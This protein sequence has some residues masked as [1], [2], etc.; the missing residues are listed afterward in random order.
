MNPAS[1]SS[2]PA[3]P[4]AQRP[5]SPHPGLGDEPKIVEEDAGDD[6]VSGKDESSR[7]S[8]S[9]EDLH[10]DE[11]TGLTKKD[12]Q[13]KQ[14]KRRRNA[15]LDQRIARE[16][17]L[18]A[19]ERKEADK[20]VVRKLVINGVLILLWYLFSL[21]ISIVCLPNPSLTPRKSVV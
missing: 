14:K 6:P 13:R 8:F 12:K 17:N 15:R 1:Q 7:D 16:K 11:E 4:G 19:D 18:S 20:D 3:R 2:T 10:D 9:D 21:S 5:R